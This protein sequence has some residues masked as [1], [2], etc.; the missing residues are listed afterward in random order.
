MFGR[1]TRVSYRR[2][3][4]RPDGLR[5]LG[6]EGISLVQ[7]R[8][9]DLT[10][11]GVWSEDEAGE[12]KIERQWSVD[13]VALLVPRIANGTVLD[14]GDVEM[15]G[16]EITGS[17]GFPE[18]TGTGGL[19]APAPLTPPLHPASP[20]NVN[21]VRTATRQ[22]ADRRSLSHAT[23][24]FTRLRGRGTPMVFHPE[25]PDPSDGVHNGEGDRR[26]ALYGR[27]ELPD[28]TPRNRLPHP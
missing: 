7:E 16:D 13:L 18:L 27:E 22:L 11:T 21:T 26:S 3:R 17:P 12:S 10:W 9:E 8:V 28:G 6:S 4:G 19:N 2:R 15:P 25:R 1:G 14:S 24:G 20:S 23:G 5:D